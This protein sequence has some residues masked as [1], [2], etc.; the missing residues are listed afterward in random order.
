MNKLY[1][2]L[3]AFLLLPGI[4]A[5]L[6]V[7]EE[8]GTG[9]GRWSKSPELLKA[10]PEPVPISSQTLSGRGDSPA[11]RKASVGLAVRTPWTTSRI[12]GSPDPPHPYRIV[13][14]FPKL[15]FKNPI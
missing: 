5:G 10:R 14:A 12:T 3:I 7:C 8:M 11:A 2:L 9:T 13:R 6:R 4:G 1:L 15:T